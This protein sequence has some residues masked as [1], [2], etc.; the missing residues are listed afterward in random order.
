MKNGFGRGTFYVEKQTSWRETR[1]VCLC[2]PGFDSLTRLPR[3]K[4]SL[5]KDGR[6]G[7]DQ[8]MLIVLAARSDG[9][10]GGGGLSTI[11]RVLENMTPVLLVTSP[12]R[13]DT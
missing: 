6:W 13:R 9:E 11:C 1:N 4:G 5:L 12:L 8:G 3:A 7:I 2:Q 10:G